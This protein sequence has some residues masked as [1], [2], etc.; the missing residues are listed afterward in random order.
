MS[1][2]DY[3]NRNTPIIPH[4]PGSCQEY[5][6]KKRIGNSVYVVNAY[7]K[8]TAESFSEKVLRIVKNDLTFSAKCGTISLSQTG[9]LLER[10]SI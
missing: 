3:K 9:G 10:G 5:C 1:T 8:E 6:Y 4:T 7:F 2:T